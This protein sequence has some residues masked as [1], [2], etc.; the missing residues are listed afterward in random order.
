MNI[1]DL[2]IRLNAAQ[3]KIEE[4]LCEL[5]LPDDVE[6]N[7]Q[8]ESDDDGSFIVCLVAT[9]ACDPPETDFHPNKRKN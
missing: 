7:A 5:E 1:S 2:K 6:L 4:V 3:K 8:I 9:V